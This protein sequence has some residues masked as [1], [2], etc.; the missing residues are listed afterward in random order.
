MQYPTTIRCKILQSH[1]WDTC[2]IAEA[3]PTQNGD[4][5]TELGQRVP[6]LRTWRLPLECWDCSRLLGV[7]FYWLSNA[8]NIA[9]QSAKYTMPG[10]IMCLGG[11][12][13]NLRRP[14]HYAWALFVES[15]KF[16]RPRLGPSSMAGINYH[17]LLIAQLRNLVSSP[18]QIVLCC[19]A[20]DIAKDELQWASLT[21]INVIDDIWWHHG[22]IFIK[23]DQPFCKRAWWLFCSPLLW[24]M[25]SGHD[26]VFRRSP[27]Q[28]QGVTRC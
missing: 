13:G 26:F 25:M 23:R 18:L 27:D 22:S 28:S 8:A 17:K 15:R 12:Q 2:L 24:N 3:S 19:L 1:I 5:S 7:P 16:W 10:L 14:R 21:C 9:L 20:V 11:W 4:M 6:T